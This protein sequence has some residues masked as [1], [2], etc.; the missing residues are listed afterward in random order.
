[1]LDR[2]NHHLFQPLLYQVAPGILPPGLIAPALRSV[3]KE[4][5]NARA[6]LADVRDIDLERKVVRAIAPDGRPLDLPYDTLVIE[7]G[8]AIADVA[9]AIRR[10]VISAL[11]RMTGLEV[12]EVSPSPCRA[13][14][15]WR[16]SGP[17]PAS[18]PPAYRP[19]RSRGSSRRRPPSRRGVGRGA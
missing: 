8:A 2:T 9:R 11:E 16:P 18:G 14:T 4:Q 13:R 19:H 12:V 1:V 3:I 7:Y 17:A 10:N 5:D 15:G 6:L